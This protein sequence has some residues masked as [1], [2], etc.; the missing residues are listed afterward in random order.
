MKIFGRNAENGIAELSQLDS[1]L[2][3]HANK[4]SE[5]KI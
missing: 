3:H 4:L 5:V 2:E 1:R